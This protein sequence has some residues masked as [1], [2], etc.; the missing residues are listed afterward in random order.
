MCVTQEGYLEQSTFTYPNGDKVKVFPIKNCTS[1]EY[2][3]VYA[4]FEMLGSN[5]L[6]VSSVRVTAD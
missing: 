2:G 4:L 1:I 5:H 3:H 6:L